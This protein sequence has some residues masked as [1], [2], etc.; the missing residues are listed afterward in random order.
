MLSSDWIGELKLVIAWQF[1]INGASGINSV[2]FH[3]SIF[4]GASRKFPPVGGRPLSVAYVEWI[5]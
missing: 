3:R 5:G 4:L 1:P 2:I